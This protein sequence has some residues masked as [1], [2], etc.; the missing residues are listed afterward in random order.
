MAND[1]TVPEQEAYIRLSHGNEKDLMGLIIGEDYTEAYEA[2]ADLAKILGAGNSVKTYMRYGEMDMAYVA[3]NK[4]LARQW[5]PVT[6]NLPEDGEYT[7]SLTNSST[8]DAL[9]GVYLIDYT[10]NEITNLIENDYTFVATGGT[11]SNRF[12]INATVGERQTQTEID[13]VGANK[14]GDEPIKFLY[15]DKVF[16]WHHGVIYDATGKKVR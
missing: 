16:I 3:I 14:N 9:E 8:V 13:V 6:V 12:A 4:V 15:H 7:F 5:I 2:N 1:E 10:S 11:I